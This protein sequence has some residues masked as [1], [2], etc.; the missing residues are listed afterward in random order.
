VTSRHS[1]TLVLAVLLSA[2]AGETPDPLPSADAYVLEIESATL[3][4]QPDVSYSGRVPDSVGP[5]QSLHLILSLTDTELR[6]WVTAPFGEPREYR[7]GL[8]DGSGPFTLTPGEPAAITG[9]SLAMDA[10]LELRRITLEASVDESG[11]LLWN[12]RASFWGI[13]TLTSTD[14]FTPYD[15]RGT[16]AG[17]VDD[18]APT[19]RL[20]R[21]TVDTHP[22]R[23]L[24][25]WEAFVVQ[26]SEPTDLGAADVVVDGTTH[27][28]APPSA[29]PSTRLTVLPTTWWPPADAVSVAVL[30][31]YEDRNGVAGTPLR[32]RFATFGNLPPTTFVAFEGGASASVEPWGSEGPATVPSFAG[33]TDGCLALARPLRGAIGF[34]ARLADMAGITGVRAR[35]RVLTTASDVPTSTSGSYDLRIEVAPEGSRD[36]TVLTDRVSVPRATLP[37]PYVGDSGWIEVGVDLASTVDSIGVGF[38]LDGYYDGVVLMLL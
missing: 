34:Y 38:E 30:E 28:I 11:E 13:E 14:V 4:E 31:T 26:A 1:A 16:L 37:D 29:D 22:D 20:E 35:V 10:A 5:G 7:A 19:V 23:P 6:A 8:R 24:Y 36:A 3:E 32:D 33:C 18:D 9:E 12:G 2:C 25:P 27:E 15:V 21:A 17:R